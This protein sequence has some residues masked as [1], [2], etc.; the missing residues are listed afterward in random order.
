[1]VLKKRLFIQNCIVINYKVF[2]STHF[3]YPKAD[4]GQFHLFLTGLVRNRSA[5]TLPIRNNHIPALQAGNLKFKPGATDMADL[6]A[7]VFVLKAWK[8]RS[9]FNPGIAAIKHRFIVTAA[10]AVWFL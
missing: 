8:P 1:M 3:G 5:Q 10:A 9:I 6:T 2:L 7:R 4:A